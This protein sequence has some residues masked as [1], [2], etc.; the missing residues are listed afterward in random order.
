M[1]YCW[2]VL[3]VWSQFATIG[4]C[5]D[6]PQF[7]GPTGMGL[8]TSDRLPLRWNAD[9]NVT[10]KV[11]IPGAGWSSPIVVGN[12]I[13]LTA[14][15]PIADGKDLQL[16]AICMSV[17]DGRIA[18]ETEV[19]RQNG[20]KAPA[21]HKKNSHASPTP[22]VENNRLYV[23]FGHQGTACLDLQ[24][25]I[26][27]RNDELRYPPNHGNG[28]SPII[29]G[30]LLVFSCDGSADPF[31]VALNKADGKVR[32]KTPRSVD[33][34]KKFS[35]STPTA[36]E[37]DGRTQIIS[38]GSG[39][40][41]AYEPADGKEIW[42]V[43][44]EGYSVVPKPVFGHGL[45]FISSGYETPELFAIRTDGRGDVTETHVAWSEKKG[46]PNTP[47]P[48]LVGDELYV[49]SDAGI[50]SCFDARTGKLH[51]RNRIGGKF[52][53]SPLHAGGRIYLQSEGGVGTIL[54]AAKEFEVLAT[55][56]LEEMT[57]ASPAAVDA[58]LYI[59]SEANLYRI[60]D[61]K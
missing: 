58:T 32:W 24:G 46:A 26:L 57:L 4:Y 37:V 47:S 21:I 12:R 60:E 28:G 16:T 54:R 5:A 38:P 33:H 49:I 34:F 13:Y 2:L 7:R 53:S 48:L 22:L 14:A 41:C 59:R 19:F 29:V 6:W 8:V 11:P 35:F 45:V 40:V 44:Y 1:K 52:S 55:N 3:L 23:H 20:E 18:W 56:N 50:A 27:W 15:V 42:Q 31:V 17:A 61:R 36:I 25:E 10:W 30:D 39:Q 9:E 43:R 51:W